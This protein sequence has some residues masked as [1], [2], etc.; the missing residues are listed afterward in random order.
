MLRCFHTKKISGCSWVSIEKYL[1]VIDEDKESYCDIEIRADWRKITPITKD[2][3]A[4]LRILSFDI[5]CYSNDGSFPQARRGADKIIQIG[6]TYT[7]LGESDPYRQHIVCLDKTDD[8]E[9][10]IVEWYDTER[11]MVHGW[12]KEVI[13][14]DCDIITGYNIFFFDEPYIHDRCE[15]HLNLMHEVIKMSKLKNYECRYRDFKLASTY[16]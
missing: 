1:T 16:P 2:R 15:E 14:S 8:I 7:Y 13:R 6:S 5:E 4:P 10:V 11:E 12:I 3:N 9:N